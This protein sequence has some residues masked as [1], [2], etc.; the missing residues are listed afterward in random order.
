MALDIREKRE[1][2]TTV[3]ETAVSNGSSFMLTT[4]VFK[5][6]C[7]IDD[8]KTEVKQTLPTLEPRQAL[9]FFFALGMRLWQTHSFA[10]KEDDLVKWKFVAT[11]YFNFQNP[12]QIR[13]S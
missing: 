11:S 8:W 3:L 7:S 6:S 2:S 12:A 13:G 9:N 5:K 4:L 10:G 1:S